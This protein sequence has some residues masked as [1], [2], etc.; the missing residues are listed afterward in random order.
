MCSVSLVE[1]PEG[2]V[3]D[4]VTEYRHHSVCGSTEVLEEF[5]AAQAGSWE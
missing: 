3:G 4:F 5:S 1:L 2:Y